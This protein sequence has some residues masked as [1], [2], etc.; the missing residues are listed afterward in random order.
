MKTGVELGFYWG[1]YGG[2]LV[3][4]VTKGTK[5]T[6]Q[7]QAT[8]GALSSDAR[9]RAAI[10]ASLDAI[11]LLEAVR[12]PRSQEILDFVFVDLNSKGAELVSLPREAIL[13]QRLCELLPINRS[14]GFFE[15]YKQVVE[16][17]TSLE[18]EFPISGQPGLVA[19]WLH[20]QVVP[21]GDGI[22]IT[23]RDISERKRNEMLLQERQAQYQAVWQ[24]L[25]DL[26]AHVSREGV[27]LSYSHTTA[28]S[29]LVPTDVDPVGK[30]IFTCLP[31]EVAQRQW[32]GIQAALNTGQLQVYEQQ[33][34]IG[35]HIQY[36]EV[37]IV[38][39][40][41]D[42]ALIIVRDITERVR[43]EQALRESE[44]RY[45]TLY[46]AIPDMILEVTRAGYI[47]GCKVPPG[48]PTRYPAEACVGRY[49]EE[50]FPEA[51]V[52]GYQ[53]LINR[54]LETQKI[55][56][57]EYGTDFPEGIPQY[58][59][60]CV[61]P[62]GSDQVYI[63]VRD[64]TERKRAELALQEIE[65]T[66]RA[67]LQAIPDLILRFDRQ[68]TCLS[69]MS[70][71]DV[72]L[73]SPAEN[74]LGK[75]L[76]EILPQPLAEQRLYYIE[77]A[78]STQ[79]RQIYEYSINVAGELR[80]EEARV[81]PLN[82]HEV[83]VIVRDITAR[84]MAQQSLLEKTQ[85]LRQ[86]QRIARLGNWSFE[87]ASRQLTWSEELFHLFGLSP[88]QPPPSLAEH[89]QQIHPEDRQLWLQHV[90]AT[91]EEGIPQSWDFRICRAD[92]EVRYLSARSQAEQVNGEVVRI[93]GTA[94]D[95]TEK[96][97][98]EL[99]LQESEQ[100]FRALFENA[101]V[102]ILIQEAETG[103]VIDA[104]RRAITSYGLS[105]LEALQAFD[106]FGDPP[107]S[108]ADLLPYLEQV[109]QKGSVRFEWRSRRVNGEIFWEDVF[110]QPMVLRGIPRLVSTSVDITDRKLAQDEL[111]YRSRL[112]RLLIDLSM[113]FINASEAALDESIQQALA[114]VGQFVE[115][116]RAY[117]FTYNH[118]QGLTRNTHEWCRAG[119]EPQIHH[120]Q[121][122]P[123]SVVAKMFDCH[124]QGDPYILSD[125]STLSPTDP[126]RQTL[127]PQGI[128]SLLT[129]PLY[130][131]GT[132]PGFVGFDA[133]CRQR[134]WKAG[135]ITLLQILAELFVN[136]HLK[137][138]NE[139][140][141][142][143]AQ[144]QLQASTLLAQQMAD[145]AE[146]ANQAKSQFLATMSHEL[147]TPMNAVIG[148]TGLLL[149]TDLDEQQQDFVQTIRHS[150]EVLLSLINDI[151]DL[152][153]IESERLEL[154]EN[155]FSLRQ[156]VEDLLDLMAIQAQDKT[157][158]LRTANGVELAALVDPTLPDTLIGDSARLRQ[159]LIN[160]LSNAL[161]FTPAGEVVLTIQP[162][163]RDPEARQQELYFQVRDTGIGIPP[164]KRHRLFQPF[165]Q[166]D[167]SI[168]RQ[169]GGTGLGLVISQRLCQ[170]MG[171]TIEVV[172]EPGAGSTFA[173]RLSFQVVDPPLPQPQLN[174]QG[175]RLLVVDDN[176]TNR[177]ILTLQTK[178]WGMEVVSCA[179]PA[180]AL[181]LSL[182]HH[183]FDL[184]ILDHQ[185]PEMDGLT[186]ATCLQTKDPQLRLILLT[187]RD[188]NS[189][190]Q[191]PAIS[192]YLT[193][194]VKASQLRTLVQQLLGQEQERGSPDE[195][196]RKTFSGSG[197]CEMAS[198]YPLRILVAE[199]NPV[200]Q[201]VTRLMLERLG[202]RPDIVANGLEAVQA[203]QL[204]PYDLVLM[205][206][207]M[208]Q[209]D[210][211]SATRRIRAELPPERQPRI[212]ALTA[213]VLPESYAEA[214]AAGVNDYLTKPLERS[215]LLRV[216]QAS[217][218]EPLLSPS[219]SAASAPPTES[220]AEAIDAAT[221]KT[222]EAAIGSQAVLQEMINSYL[223]EGQ[224]QIGS[225]QSAFI[226]RDPQALYRWAHRLKGSSS[227]LGAKELARLCQEVER[228]TRT[229][230]IDW[231]L[232][233][234]VFSQIQAEYQR[235]A[236]SLAAH[237]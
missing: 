106:R 16:S 119:I 192:A 37:R 144:A 61:V 35:E 21:I 153:K 73:Y 180:E 58:R 55:E 167:S 172:S 86:A 17:Q 51:D 210:G 44:L 189:I 127:E 211:L 237:T 70:G 76:Q 2:A 65:N 148:M 64:I 99:A 171:G 193:K 135:D 25:P 131:E 221:F 45:R 204:R 102:S 48:F 233:E 105:S 31:Q 26:M 134:Q 46:E 66:Q 178:A 12:D 27:Y 14:E 20:H 226:E 5:A 121:T 33:I 122:V 6:G 42:E 162:G 74:H 228:L 49:M 113:Q 77:R 166:V 235:V 67:I 128:Q 209:L 22:L 91:L 161:K 118:E 200:N 173:F 123:L 75:P 168:S 142:R 177:K 114:A 133:V 81:V 68:G 234:S 79:E 215:A 155:P 196:S 97:L 138:R 208:P 39:S 220:A 43:A 13:G 229:E 56:Y 130:F 52:E 126:L 87:V 203:L 50:L 78:L 125:L 18:E 112:E 212:V 100:Q 41:P 150:S 159:I 170:L 194:P 141:I 40:G 160:L 190:T 117:L 94:M 223:Q 60:A 32:Q 95:I 107:Y 187:S 157:K 111:D 96:K 143:A 7:A 224:T 191:H 71:G 10:E 59:E 140:R 89:L 218:P 174:L 36:E 69:F 54:V 139:A 62:Q 57:L 185:M 80:H 202:Y 165:S 217:A 136:A 214:A 72:R 38:P 90:Q 8:E 147:R 151:L 82:T 152:S 103:K 156:L 23:S 184:A 230:S 205:D 92:G 158:V 232:M 24:A 109:Q 188:R 236:L 83:M 108:Y 201:K 198:L 120:L 195:G 110:I 154:E 93:F 116:D 231:T 169:Y 213:N 216:L 19:N 181:A 219:A 88:E 163:N 115:V 132:C 98:A 182:D 183:P 11:Y 4:K 145:A 53:V 28:F 104:N 85:Q 29:D 30:T 124:R 146:A 34:T 227:T 186:L 129:I 199:D 149:D 176:A 206:M 84:V 222:L 175:K 225:L 15:K 197:G 1:A 3:S 164:E 9:F 207:Q 101:A 179:S 63:L 137:Q 47:L